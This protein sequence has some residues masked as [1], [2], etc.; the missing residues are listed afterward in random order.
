MQVQEKVPI[1]PRIPEQFVTGI[2]KL[3]AAGV[4]TPIQATDILASWPLDDDWRHGF[5]T[6]REH[7][8][9]FIDSLHDAVTNDTEAGLSVEVIS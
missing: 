1:Q 5:R 6:L 2:A 4:L 9:A 8:V 3:E 7:T